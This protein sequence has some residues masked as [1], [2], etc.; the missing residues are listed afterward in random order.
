LVPHWM[1]L[2]AFQ[3][4]RVGEYHGMIN[5]LVI[6]TNVFLHS[7]NPHDQ[8]FTVSNGFLLSLAANSTLICVDDGADFLVEARNRSAIISEYRQHIFATST[9]Y[10]IL[11]VLFSTGRVKMV[12]RNVSRN[13]T[14]LIPR[15]VTDPTDRIFLRVALNSADKILVSHDYRDF[16]PRRRKNIQNQVG[17]VVCGAEECIPDL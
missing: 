12:S 1:K 13:L 6:D 2:L 17:V 5:E 4:L 15:L 16:S 8:F 3:W 11:T 9:A 7:Y 14:R 10:Q